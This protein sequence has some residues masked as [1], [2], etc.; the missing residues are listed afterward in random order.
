M[1]ESSKQ[2]VRDY[3]LPGVAGLLILKLIWPYKMTALAAAS[4]TLLYLELVHPDQSPLR[5]YR[6]TT[7][8]T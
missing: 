5:Q 2:L 1:E 4:T 3:V 7:E 8:V 6:K